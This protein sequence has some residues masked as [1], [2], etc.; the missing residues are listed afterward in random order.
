MANE[1][2]TKAYKELIKAQEEL[3]RIVKEEY[4]IGSWVAECF[5]KHKIVCQVSAYS[6]SDGEFINV[7][8]GGNG[9]PRMVHIALLEK[10]DAPEWAK[11]KEGAK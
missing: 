10:C 5:G 11:E 8:V 4:P 7:A 1:R 6:D 3:A 2:I 9:Y